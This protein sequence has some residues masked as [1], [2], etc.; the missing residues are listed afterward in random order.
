MNSQDQNNDE[1]RPLVTPLVP[2]DEKAQRLIGKLGLQWYDRLKD[3]FEQSYM[4]TLAEELSA[5]IGRGVPVFPPI[6][7]MFRAF[8]LCPFDK[9]KAV[10]MGQDPY[11]DKNASGVAFECKEFRSPSYKLMEDVYDDDYPHDFNTKLMDGDLSG[12]AQQGVLLINVALTVP[13][14]KQTGHIGLWQPFIGKVMELLTFD[15]RPKVFVLLGSH[16]HSYSKWVLPPSID[17]C[18]EHPAYAAREKR[19]WDAA[20]MF[21]KVNAFLI[22]NHIMPIEW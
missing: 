15:R 14:D 12:W 20:G 6:D 22:E 11:M 17:F 4:K 16:A 1:M 10:F 7:S 5:T 2:M 21:K 13:A 3:E 18:Y 8:L 19:K 9:V